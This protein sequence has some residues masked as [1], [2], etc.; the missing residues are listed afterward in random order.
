LGRRD[1]EDAKRVVLDE[2]ERTDFEAFPISALL[3]ALMRTSDEAS[4]LASVCERLAERHHDESLYAL[5][6]QLAFLRLE[7]DEAARLAASWAADEILN[8]HAAAVAVYLLA[9][10]EGDLDSALAL[11]RTALAR[12][13]HTQELVNNVAYVLALAGKLSEADQLLPRETGGSVFLT[14]TRALVDILAGR[15][16]EGIKGYDRAYELATKHSDPDLPQLVLA[17]RQLAL[18]RASK[19]GLV[20]LGD[21]TVMLPSGWETHPH[22][23]LVK[24]KAEREGVDCSTVA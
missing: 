7:F 11:G 15:I 12:A 19:R 22:F 5:R 1:R 9:D 6:T 4:E 14:A 3:P 18:Y 10:V 2:L 21:V 13:G 20:D 17:N 16:E 23:A 8:P 24:W